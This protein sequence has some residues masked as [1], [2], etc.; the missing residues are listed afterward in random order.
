MGS[1]T[2]LA[3]LAGAP[4]DTAKSTGIATVLAVLITGAVTLATQRAAAKAS[5]RNQDVASRTDIEK[6]AFERAKGFYTDTIDRQ[7]HEIHELE[8]DV[9]RLKARVTDLERDLGTAQAALRL[10]FPDE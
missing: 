6:E 4:G 9:D 2:L 8:A 3:T 1:L 10:R 5:V 7:A